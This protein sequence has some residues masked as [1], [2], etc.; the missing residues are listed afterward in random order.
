MA[1]KRQRRAKRM[2]IENVRTI[3]NLRFESGPTSLL[4]AATLR[5][6]ARH[7][8]IAFFGALLT[9]VVISVY[10]DVSVEQPF[11]ARQLPVYLC[12]PV[13]L[14]MIVAYPLLDWWPSFSQHLAREWAGRRFMRACGSFGLVVVGLAPVFVAPGDHSERVLISLSVLGAALGVLFVTV[15]GQL[16]WLPVLTIGLIAI[17]R[18]LSPADQGIVVQWFS[19]AMATPLALVAYAVC[20]S[21]YCVFASPQESAGRRSRFP[22]WANKTSSSAL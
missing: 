12:L 15:L 21:L 8:L 16:Y 20:S 19:N 6:R 10:F 2:G 5:L 1:A 4:N 3:A 18:L 11:G 14:S 22:A 9:G 17:P 13:L 7:W